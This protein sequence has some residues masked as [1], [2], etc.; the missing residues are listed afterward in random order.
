MHAPPGRDGCG[1]LS[2]ELDQARANENAVASA[3]CAKQ[4]GHPGPEPQGVPIWA[5]WSARCSRTA[6]LRHV[7]NRLKETSAAGDLQTTIARGKS[8]HRS[9]RRVRPDKKQIVLIA[10]V[11]TPVIAALMALLLTGSQRHQLDSDV[12]GRL[13]AC[14]RRAAEDQGFTKKGFVSSSRLLQRHAI[15]IRRGSAHRAHQRLLRHRSTIPTR[16]S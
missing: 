3:L 11:A 7:Q 12:E 10:A 9:D 2:K 14:A 6:T 5:C 1:R 8:G 15:G 4:V 16:S 13:G